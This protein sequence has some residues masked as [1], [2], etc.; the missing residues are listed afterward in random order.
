[1]LKNWIRGP[2]LV[3]MMALFATTPLYGQDAPTHV[4]HWDGAIQVPGQ[5]LEI[6]VDLAREAGAWKGDISIPLQQVED[7][8]LG[9]F[10]VDG[11]EITFGMVGVPG[12]PTFQGA[13]S[14]DGQTLSGTFSQGGQSFPFTL[15]RGG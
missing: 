13:L 2:F 5:A 1:M 14:E 15:T 6:N 12:D 11:M 7:F 8:A 9:G 3:V 10:L 4:G